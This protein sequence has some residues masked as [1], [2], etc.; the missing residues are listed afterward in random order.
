MSGLMKEYDAI[1]LADLERKITEKADLLNKCIVKAIDSRDN[2]E[3]ERLKGLKAQCDAEL[4]LIKYIKNGM[5]GEF[6]IC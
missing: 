4:R 3:C 6:H 1:K 5:S 2:T